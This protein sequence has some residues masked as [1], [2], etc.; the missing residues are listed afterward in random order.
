MC[1]AAAGLVELKSH[2]HDRDV[3][4]E[5]VDRPRT[6][7]LES[8]AA[9]AADG[10]LVEGTD[11]CLDSLSGES[12]GDI[13]DHYLYELMATTSAGKRRIHP[14]PEEEQTLP[15]EYAGESDE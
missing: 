11:F 15:T 3:L 7:I 8:G 10:P 2:D 14:H 6:R 4:V 9:I 13:A 1:S 5:R 12:G